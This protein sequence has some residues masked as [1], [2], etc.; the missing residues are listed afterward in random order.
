MPP[1]G[2]PRLSSNGP[3][4]RHL[5]E[6][7]VYEDAQIRTFFSEA[8]D[9]LM[10][11]VR[12]APDLALTFTKSSWVTAWWRTCK[13]TNPAWTAPPPAVPRTRSRRSY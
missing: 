10:R 9:L 5:V 7:G 3:R 8:D 13:P 12:E 11:L 4:I 2:K 1:L 6:N